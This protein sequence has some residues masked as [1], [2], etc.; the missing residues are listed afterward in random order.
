MRNLSTPASNAGA[1]RP[2]SSGLGFPLAS[3]NQA[4]YKGKNILKKVTNS[5]KKY[6]PFRC[7]FFKS[8]NL[9]IFFQELF[10][11]QA[12]SNF[13]DGNVKLTFPSKLYL[14]FHDKKSSFVIFFYEWNM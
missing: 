6:V 1:R 7:M 14:F 9:T 10:P 12:L 2:S 8:N 3:P 13:R 11:H 5:R 4:R